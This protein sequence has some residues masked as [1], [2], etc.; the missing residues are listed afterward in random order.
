MNVDVEE[1]GKAEEKMLK[2]RRKNELL[3]EQIKQQQIN[4]DTR[5]ERDKEL[6]SNKEALKARKEKIESDHNIRFERLGEQMRAQE[7]RHAALIEK[8]AILEAQLKNQK[9]SKEDLFQLKEKQRDLEER[10]N[11][12]KGGQ[13]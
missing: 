3:E 12:V 7:V 6:E 11:L 9:H 8:K 2:L 5:K 1:I 4:Y 13:F 10:Y